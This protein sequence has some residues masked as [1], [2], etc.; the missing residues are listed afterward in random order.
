MNRPEKASVI[1]IE[2]DGKT[3]RGS[4]RVSRGILTVTSLYGEKSTQVGGL[5]PEV[6]AR[7][8]LLELVDAGAAT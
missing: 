1:A 6:L 2:K 7:I 8:L 3:Y 4:Y 5:A